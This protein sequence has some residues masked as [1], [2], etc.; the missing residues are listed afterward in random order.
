LVLDGLAPYRQ[1]L[2]LTAGSLLLSVLFGLLKLPAALLLGPMIAAILVEVGGGQIR[3]PRILLYTCQALIGC[4]IARAL[5][6]DLLSSLVTRWPMFL[7]VVLAVIAMSALI[8][9]LM[10]RWRI[11]PGTTAV[12]GLSPGAASAMVLMAGAFGADP[13]LV[14]FMQYFRVVLVATVATIVARVWVGPHASA[15]A[16]IWFPTLHALPFAET[17][18][19]ALGGGL[20]GR[21]TRIPAG[22]FLVPMIGGAVLRSGGIVTIELP[23]WLL[24]VSYAFLGWSIG[25]GFTREI[26]AHALR[27]LP[28]TTLAILTLMLFAGGLALVLVRGFGVDPLTAYLATSPGGADSVAIIA[29]SSRVNISFVMA[30]QTMRF[31]LV[32][33]LGPPVSRFVARHIPAPPDRLAPDEVK[34]QLLNQLREDEGELD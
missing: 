34:P 25:L 16:P 11:L 29:A 10:S 12:W 31:M 20:I 22:I 28:Q 3:L 23:P 27:A 14:A 1:W 5:T 8:G 9:W 30:M 4:M 24:A 2:V 32:L 17:V 26:L 13:R 7:A 15:S 19:L 33:I 21:A 6:P 18:A